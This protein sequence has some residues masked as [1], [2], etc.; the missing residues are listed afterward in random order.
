MSMLEVAEAF[1]QSFEQTT[2]T[3]TGEAITKRRVDAPDW[4]QD[5]VRELHEGHAPNDWLYRAIEQ[6]ADAIVDSEAATGAFPEPDVYDS[7]LYAW[8]TDYPDAASFCDY[9]TEQEGGATLME[10]LQRGQRFALEH[11]Y[12]ELWHLLMTRADH[13][14]E[15]GVDEEEGEEGDDVASGAA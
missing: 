15:V 13:L 7:Q 14:A 11:L 3:T 12:D 8:L 6:C 5:I 2:R 4:V 9:G 1:A 10:T